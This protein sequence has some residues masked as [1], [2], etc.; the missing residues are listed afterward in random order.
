LYLSLDTEGEK[1]EYESEYS[2]GR[3]VDFQCE[4][5]AVFTLLKG[6][7]TESTDLVDEATWFEKRGQRK[8]IRDQRRENRLP[9][10]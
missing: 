2:H 3:S 1:N 4:Y 9:K 6:R 5:E 10:F 8:V 7:L